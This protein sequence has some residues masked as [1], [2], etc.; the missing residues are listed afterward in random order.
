MT[1]EELKLKLASTNQ[2]Q[3]SASMRQPSMP[4]PIQMTKNLMQSL[5]RNVQSV[6]A[7]NNL[8]ISSED[9]QKRLSICSGCEFFQQAQQRCGKCGCY[10]AVKT[11]LKAERCPIGKW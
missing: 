11:Y 4:S 10:M 6:A 7:G 9:A 2:V 3:Q 8:R 1:K 5:G